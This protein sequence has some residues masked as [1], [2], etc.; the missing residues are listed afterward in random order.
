MSLILE[1]IMSIELFKLG[2]DLFDIEVMLCVG[3]DV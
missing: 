3:E 1:I 2:V